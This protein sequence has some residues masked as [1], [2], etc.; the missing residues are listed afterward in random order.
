MSRA[1]WISRSNENGW[2]SPNAGACADA[3][4]PGAATSSARED[5]VNAKLRRDKRSA[6][7]LLTTRGASPSGQERILPRRE[8]A[9]APANSD[10]HNAISARP[11]RE[12]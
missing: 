1:R 4:L 3:C 11:A 8:I 7:F 10:F 2:A 9:A 6:Q 12:V 5:T